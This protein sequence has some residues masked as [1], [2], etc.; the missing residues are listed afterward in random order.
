ML[1]N[2]SKPLN[3]TGYWNESYN[4]S[5]FTKISMSMIF[6]SQR[7][8]CDFYPVSGANE[9]GTRH[10]FSWND[11]GNDNGKRIVAGWL[12]FAG[13]YIDQAKLCVSYNLNAWVELDLSYITVEKIIGYP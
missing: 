9:K 12:T 7:H 11:Y 10:S 1:F 13:R 4:F 5:N 8:V 6:L 3:G 2:G